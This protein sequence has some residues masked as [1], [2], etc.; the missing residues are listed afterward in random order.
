MI[1]PQVHGKFLYVGD[2]KFLVRG[3]TYGAFR[4]DEHEKEYVDA[5]VIERDF[6]GMVAAGINTVR[7][8]HTMP[9]RALLDIAH[10]HGLRVMVG[11]SAEQ[12][13]GYLIDRK[14]APSVARLIRQK[15]LAVAGHP[16][17]LCYALGNEI[18]PQLVRWLGAKQIERYLAKLYRVV[19]RADPGG[20]VTYVNFPTTEYLQLPFL[21]LISF[22][23][24]QQPAQLQA[25]LARLHSIAIDRPLILSEV[26]L[27]SLRNGLANQAQVLDWQIRLAFAAG[28]AGTIVFS[29]TDEWYRAGEDVRDWAFGLT[30]EQRHPKP[31]LMAVKRAYEEAPFS[32]QRHWPRMSVVDAR[33]TDRADQ[34]CMDGLQDLDYPNFEVIVIDDGSRDITAEIVRG[35][36]VKLISTENRGLSA[37]RNTGWQAATGEIVAYIDDDAYPDPHWLRYLA[38]VFVGSTCAAAGGP[39]LAPAGDG[40]IAECVA[41]ALVV[42]LTCCYR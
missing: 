32:D 31:A 1:R 24:T 26:G 30:D 41:Q 13:V 39:N 12:Y 34:D 16:A 29:W 19:K 25:Y 37:A 10:R 22:N 8:P 35:Y 15:V 7:I 42:R 4:P 38:H 14:G 28:C 27:D 18:S 3:V 17:L 6:A 2:T 23:S 11:L 36:G 40:A 21:D 33:I 5:E 9:P 20:L